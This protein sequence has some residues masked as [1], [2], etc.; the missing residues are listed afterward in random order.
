MAQSFKETAHLRTNKKNFD[1]GWERVF[2]KKELECEE[3]N[4][5]HES[6]KKRVHPHTVECGEEYELLM[7]DDCEKKAWDD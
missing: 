1:E 3:C 2:G 6:V 4:I 7:C 5:K